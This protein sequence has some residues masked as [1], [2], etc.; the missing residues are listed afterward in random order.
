MSCS[1]S[2]VLKGSSL[3]VLGERL[4]HCF[5]NGEL[6][7]QAITH[8]S[9]AAGNNERL[10]FLGDAIVD[11]LIGEA[12]FHR[13]PQLSEGDLS[14]LR[15][16]LVRKE[17]LAELARGFGLGE[18][19]LLGAGELKSGGANR[20]SILGDALEAIIAAIYLDAGIDAVR[21]RVLD[22]FASRLAALA[23]DS[24][25][26]AKTRLQELLQARKLSLPRY[27]V[28]AVRGPAHDQHFEVLAHVPS[29][30]Q[31]VE[32]R[33]KSRRAAEQAA[34]QV[35]LKKLGDA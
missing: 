15:A 18:H 22:W 20:D 32:G 26:D 25:K 27:E 11:M 1:E 17:T 24:G 34:A 6:L 28:R 2:N 23:T 21:A 31:A 4:G 13:F 8:R 12:L 16:S 3:E 35:A 33:G 5:R 19:L 29:L 7:R 30:P 9:F 10:E 14:R